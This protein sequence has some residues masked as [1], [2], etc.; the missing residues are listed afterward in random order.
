[1]LALARTPGRDSYTRAANDDRING[2]PGTRTKYGYDPLDR[3]SSATGVSALTWTY[4]GVGNRQT[5]VGGAAPTYPTATATLTYNNRGRL[6]SATNTITES[7]AYNALGQR[8]S[9]SGGGVSIVFMYDE[10][11]HLL[12]EYTGAGSLI[13][14]TVWMED[15]PIATLRPHTGGGID[16]YYVH[17]DHLGSPRLVTRST[18]NA[19]VWRWDSDPFGTN[20]PNQNPIGLGTF[21]Y[22][23]RFPGQYYDAESG[24]NYNYFRDYDGQTGRYVESDPVLQFGRLQS[25]PVSTP[26]QLLVVPQLFASY[27]YVFETPI[28]GAD[29]YGLGPLEWL[30]WLYDFKGC[31]KAQDAVRQATRRCDAECP[32]NASLER[33]A[34]FIDKY[35]SDGGLDT[36]SIRCVCASMP[37]TCHEALTCGIGLIY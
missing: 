30:K 8:N 16:I 29:R 28:R 33:Q 14:E 17:A 32:K 15:L 35:A 9:K 3:L 13:E 22:N 5:Q 11:G 37:E 26:R 21:S 10:A 1:M 6:T 18:D 12:G 20:Q 23:L 24:L 7:Y 36:A 27:N 31:K 34:A 2:G 4:D 25:S 19:V